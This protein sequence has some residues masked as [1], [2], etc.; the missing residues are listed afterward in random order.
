MDDGRWMAADADAADEDF[1]GDGDVVDEDHDDGDVDEDFD[2]DYD[3][4]TG[5]PCTAYGLDIR[6]YT[7]C[8]YT[9]LGGAWWLALQSGHLWY[10]WPLYSASVGPMI[11]QLPPVFSPKRLSSFM[12]VFGVWCCFYNGRCGFH[13]HAVETHSFT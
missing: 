4:A 12:F 11:G 7:H 3:D 5:R 1:H 13:R 6:R 8:R 9:T 10:N 2:A